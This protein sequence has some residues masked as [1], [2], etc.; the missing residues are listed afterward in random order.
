MAFGVYVH[1]PFCL[2]I[3]PYCDFTKYELGKVMSPDLY[4]ELL[5]KEIRQRAIDLPSVEPDTIY[6]GGGTPSLLE[7]HHILSIIDE[8]AKAGFKAGSGA[9]ITLEIDPMTADAAKVDKLLEIGINRFSV[10]A[11]SFDD[12]LLKVAGRKHGSRDVEELLSI[13][14]S[15]GTNFSFDLL[16]ALPGQSVDDLRSD[17]AKALSFDPVHVSA[18]CLT[19]PE[20]HKLSF[21]RAPEDDQV[22]MFDVVEDELANAGILRYEISNFAKPGG[23]SR[24]NLLYWTDQAYWGL[25]LSSHGYAPK[26]FSAKV[27]SVSSW[28]LRYWNERAMKKYEAEIEAF[29]GRSWSYASDIPE[30][31]SEKLTLHQSLSDFCHTSLRLTR[32]LETAALRLKFGSETAALAE[33]R[34][35]QLVA[36]GLVDVTPL[37]WTLSKRGRLVA[38]LVFEKLTFLLG[39]S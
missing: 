9:E 13:L 7:P 36:D 3:C 33:K 19:V 22:E 4:V 24:H 27:D 16:F 25:G 17:V 15:K 18:Y 29:E 20:G 12:R 38:N 10:G 2:Q 37:G 5:K 30:E 23:E 26:G 28:G 21:H 14:R 8:L 32:G 1:I 6:F 34:L 11:Q 39:D 31:R 35:I